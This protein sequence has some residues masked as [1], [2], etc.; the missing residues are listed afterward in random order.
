MHRRVRTGLSPL[1]SLVAL[2]LTL[3]FPLYFSSLASDAVQFQRQ[4]GE[5]VE[6]HEARL[7]ATLWAGEVQAL[8]HERT[9]FRLRDL[10]RAA[11]NKLEGLAQFPFERITVPSPLP[12]PRFLT[13]GSSFNRSMTAARALCPTGR[14]GPRRC[15]GFPAKGG[16]STK[17]SGATNGFY[18]VP[19]TPRPID[20]P[21]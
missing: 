12:P 5:T 17:S 19:R 8:Q 15:D 9:F 13:W 10:I 4:P 14:L 11:T 7:D 18:L 2:G 1:P 20:V 16:N 3:G 6:Q 21:I